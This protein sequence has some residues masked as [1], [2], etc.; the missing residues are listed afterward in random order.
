MDLQRDDFSFHRA[1]Y[2]DISRLLYNVYFK[3]ARQG[4]ACTKTSGAKKNFSFLNL[5][6]HELLILPAD[7]HSIL[8]K[9]KIRLTDCEVLVSYNILV[10][11]N[12]KESLVHR[13]SFN[14]IGYRN[15]ENN[16]SFL[17]TSGFD[18]CPEAISFLESDDVATSTEGFLKGTF[19]KV[20][21]L[22]YE[23]ISKILYDLKGMYLKNISCQSFDLEQEFK[24]YD[25][26]LNYLPS[27]WKNTILQV[28]TKI[29]NILAN[30]HSDKQVCK[31]LIHGDL[32]YRNVLKTDGKTMYVDFDRSEISYPEYD[33]YLFIT[34]LRTHKSET[35]SYELLFNNI[36]GLIDDESALS[37]EIV[38]YDVLPDFEGNRAF[39]REIKLLFLYRTLILTLQYFTTKK[40]LSENI[41]KYANE[42]LDKYL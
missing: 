40:E 25:Y 34:D 6:L 5:P 4:L 18:K 19:L 32:T 21:D 39:A 22:N 3:I 15:V 20:E 30:N 29:R 14:R 26:L 9:Q 2:P 36:F 8:E 31:T 42:G 7:Y 17:K 24:Q 16:Y 27:D 41:L 38:Y 12:K 37:N 13:C 10:A 35:P 28:Q 23:A 11:I 33:F 1:F